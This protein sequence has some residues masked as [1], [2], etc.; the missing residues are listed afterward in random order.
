MRHAA[1]FLNVL[2]LVHVLVRRGRQNR[3][4]IVVLFEADIVFTSVCSC[5]SLCMCVSISVQTTDDLLLS[6]D[7]TCCELV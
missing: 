7:V 1:A 3:V 5:V 6:I 2:Q 4:I